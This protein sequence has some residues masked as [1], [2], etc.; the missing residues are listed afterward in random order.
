M[1]TKFCLSAG[2][3]KFYPALNAG[4]FRQWQRPWRYAFSYVRMPNAVWSW[5]NCTKELAQGLDCVRHKQW[6]L[7]E[8][9]YPAGVQGTL[10]W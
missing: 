4:H 6:Q 9:S 10:D 3:T 2:M 7:S 1:R 5:G 8:M